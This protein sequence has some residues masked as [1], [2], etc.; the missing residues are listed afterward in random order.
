MDINMPR[1]NG[2]EATARIK[3]RYPDVI[4]IGLSV[5]AAGRNQEAMRAA[6]ASLLLTK[7]SA[8]EQLHESIQQALKQQAQVPRPR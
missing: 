6:G 7:E 5:N 3:A 2:I 8:V 1:M 4:V